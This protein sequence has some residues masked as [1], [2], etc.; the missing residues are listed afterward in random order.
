METV[1]ECNKGAPEAFPNHRP[2]EDESE[3]VSCRKMVIVRTTLVQFSRRRDE[4]LDSIPCG[5]LKGACCI[6]IIIFIHAI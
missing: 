4:K 3:K 2:S 1:H 6:Y 5:T